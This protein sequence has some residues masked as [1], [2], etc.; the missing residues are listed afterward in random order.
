MTKDEKDTL[1][2]VIDKL[3]EQRDRALRDYVFHKVPATKEEIEQMIED[4][5]KELRDIAEGRD[6]SNQTNY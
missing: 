1:K 5:N 2:K 6:E 4:D 3:I